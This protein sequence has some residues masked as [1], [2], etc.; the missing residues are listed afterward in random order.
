MREDRKQRYSCWTSHQKPIQMEGTGGVKPG[1]TALFKGRWENKGKCVYHS[2]TE[3]YL[4]FLSLIF[5]CPVDYL[6]LEDGGEYEIQPQRQVICDTTDKEGPDSS[7]P[8]QWWK[9]TPPRAV[10]SLSALKQAAFPIFFQLPVIIIPSYL[11]PQDKSLCIRAQRA[12]TIPANVPS[13]GDFFLPLQGLTP[14]P[15]QEDPGAQEARPNTALSA[16]ALGPTPR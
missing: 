9:W 15:W 4:W 8:S 10:Q 12:L 2:Y 13:K 16:P 1:P 5:W 6:H 7:N 11:Y 14:L 3:R